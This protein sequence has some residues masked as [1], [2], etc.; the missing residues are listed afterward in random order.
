MLSSPV[1][2]HDHSEKID[3][4]ESSGDE[5]MDEGIANYIPTIALSSILTNLVYQ[6]HEH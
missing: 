1:E 6:Q 3:R 4:E 2:F 5:G